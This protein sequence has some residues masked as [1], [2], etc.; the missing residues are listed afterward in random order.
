MK[1]LVFL[2]P[3]LA[4]LAC[5]KEQGTNSLDLNPYPETAYL[6]SGPHVRWLVDLG[7]TRGLECIDVNMSCHPVDIIVYGE[8]EYAAFHTAMQ[9][10][11]V[12][13]YFNGDDWE[14]MFP[15]LA[16][17]EFNDLLEALQS[18]DCDVTIEFSN[19]KAFYI[20][21]YKTDP[22]AESPVYVIPI[23]V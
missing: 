12:Q 10:N 18:G 21:H 13:D 19:G 11:D 7:G 3:L 1:K 5:K 23:V 20:F 4:I 16:D 8:V 2:L 22:N 14:E 15:F 9:N 6:V 17:S